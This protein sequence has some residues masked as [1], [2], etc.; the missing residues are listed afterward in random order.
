MGLIKRTCKDLKD[1]KTLK[2]LYCSLVR[3]NLEYCSIIWSPF[4]K[5]NIEKLERVQR[6][7]TKFIL[8]IE[9]PYDTRLKKLNML[10]LEQRRFMSDVVFLFKA[11]NGLVNIDLHL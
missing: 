7:A 1:I 4:T 11:L 6:R 3:S 9:D 8:K 2:L 10:S 5:R